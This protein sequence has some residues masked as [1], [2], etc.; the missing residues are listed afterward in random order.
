MYDCIRHVGCKRIA[1]PN[2]ERDGS[3]QSEKKTCC[4][5]SVRRGKSPLQ[6]T[7]KLQSAVNDLASIGGQLFIIGDAFVVEQGVFVIH[8]VRTHGSEAV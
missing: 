8:G 3:H 1:D 5:R 7:V 6:W 2:V 4:F